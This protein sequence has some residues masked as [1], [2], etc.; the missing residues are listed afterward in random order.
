MQIVIGLVLIIVAAGM[1]FAGRPDKGAESAPWIA[2][3]W[4]LGQ[5]YVLAVLIVSVIGI[6]F[7]LNGWPD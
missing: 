6:A 1:L 2:R 3:P 7:I 5:S 4:I